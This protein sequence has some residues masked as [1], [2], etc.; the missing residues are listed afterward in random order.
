LRD[1]PDLIFTFAAEGH[2]WRAAYNIQ[3]GA[4]SARPAYDPDDILSTEGFPSSLRPML[5]LCARAEAW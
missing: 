2:H 1:A 4:I 3:T 5:S